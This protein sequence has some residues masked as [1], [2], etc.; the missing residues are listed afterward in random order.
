VEFHPHELLDLRDCQ[1]DAQRRRSAYA[2][3]YLKKLVNLEL[4]IPEAATDCLVAMIKEPG[5]V[6][7]GEAERRLARTLSG[8]WREVRPVALHGG[9]LVLLAS[10]LLVGYRFGPSLLFDRERAVET[11]AFSRADRAVSTNLDPIVS[12]TV[13]GTD[14]N[15]VAGTNRPVGLSDPFPQ[16]PAPRIAR[17]GSAWLWV[18]APMLVGM[19]LFQRSR[20]LGQRRLAADSPA[21]SRALDDWGVHIRRAYPTP[22]EFKRFVNRVRYLAMRL[23]A[24]RGDSAEPLG[25]QEAALVAFAAHQGLKRV[26]DDGEDAEA[27]QPFRFEID[28]TERDLFERLSGNVSIN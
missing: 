3:L 8:L 18:L 11:P 20:E 27:G 21:F 5:T 16:A 1:D 17:G 26:A 6:A 24:E 13:T 7:G 22:R 4:R 10:A 12:T 14:A 15:R 9:V 28:A 2:R 19:A 23:R 25:R